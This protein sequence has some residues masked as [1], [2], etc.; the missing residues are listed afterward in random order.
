MV[1]AFKDFKGFKQIIK[2]VFSTQI[3]YLRINEF[4][5]TEYLEERNC[6]FHHRHI[7]MIEQDYRDY[8]LVDIQREKVYL[9]GKLEKA[10]S[11]G[12][13]EKFVC[14]LMIFSLGAIVPLIRIF[15]QKH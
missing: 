2:S 10:K 7:Y 12:F 1:L 9:E 3:V 13:Y 5:I 6:L 4:W 14:P 11:S 15:F 8:S